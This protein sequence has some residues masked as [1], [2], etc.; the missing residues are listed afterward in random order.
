M[1]S[2]IEKVK[3]LKLPQT[4]MSSASDLNQHN[5]NL[6]VLNDLIIKFNQLLEEQNGEG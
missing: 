6:A 1:V 4:G 5:Y 2:T 3:P